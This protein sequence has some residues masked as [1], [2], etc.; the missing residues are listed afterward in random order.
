MT[1]GRLFGARSG[2]R[3]S[4]VDGWPQVDAEGCQLQVATSR[5]RKR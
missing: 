5:N 2:M 1:D 4:T 3:L